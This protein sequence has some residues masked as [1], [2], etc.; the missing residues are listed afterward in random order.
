[1]NKSLEE[2]ILYAVQKQDTATVKK[3]VKNG[4]RIYEPKFFWAAFGHD[5]LEQLLVETVLP[6]IPKE[7]CKMEEIYALAKFA[8]I[9]QPKHIFHV[10]HNVRA[11]EA[12]LKHPL[13]LQDIDALDNLERTPLHVACEQQNKEQVE[14]LL[15]FGANASFIGPQGTALQQVANLKQTSKWQKIVQM[16]VPKMDGTSLR[17]TL[18]ACCQL[19]T[20]VLYFVQCGA[21]PCDS[22]DNGI[23]TFHKLAAYGKVEALAQLMP[24]FEKQ[25]PTLINNFGKNA[26]QILQVNYSSSVTHLEQLYKKYK[27]Y[28]PLMIGPF[29][30]KNHDFV[31][32]L[33]TIPEAANDAKQMVE[34]MYHTAMLDGNVPAF[35][36]LA[37]FVKH[38]DP[39]T[40]LRNLAQQQITHSPEFEAW[41]NLVLALVN[42]KYD[43]GF[44]EN[45]R[46]LLFD[47]MENQCAFK[48]LMMHQL[49]KYGADPELLSGAIFFE[50]ITVK[51]MDELA[52]YLKLDSSI[53]ISVLVAMMRYNNPE[54]VEQ[55][56]NRYKITKNDKPHGKFTNPFACLLY[57][58]VTSMVGHMEILSKLLKAGVSMYEKEGNISVVMYAMQ[59]SKFQISELFNRYCYV[60]SA[61]DW[62]SIEN[63]YNKYSSTQLLELLNS[64]GTTY[65]FSGAQINIE[66]PLWNELYF[67]SVTHPKPRILHWL[68]GAGLKYKHE[69]TSY[70]LYYHA[71]AS[72]NDEVISIVANSSNTALSLPHMHALLD[73]CAKESSIPMLKRLVFTTCDLSK[74]GYYLHYVNE[75]WCLVLLR[76]HPHYA[77]TLKCKNKVL[78]VFERSLRQHTNC[79]VQLYLHKAKQYRDIVIDLN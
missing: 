77:K 30:F 19:D 21:N 37:K 65:K 75:N 62:G 18:H 3:H 46:T 16:L 2:A 31:K 4:A 44:V 53:K 11:T 79:N 25:I 74:C 48:Y 34:H 9:Y 32:E 28:V 14:Q 17:H 43:F 40:V 24:K 64:M 67:Y 59:Q 29:I 69:D 47:I 70:S 60:M 61:E 6:Q 54:M 33:L 22:D 39:N 12:V 36:C 10:L 1:M 15:K 49:I 26:F 41:K 57:H 27:I 66:H 58:S 35:K 8:N 38:P 45:N 72:G 56:L 42:Q 52:P 78:K 20:A 73:T 63:A 7:S 71:L 23:T 55:F 13:G 51:D 50:A 76:Y 68:L 5:E